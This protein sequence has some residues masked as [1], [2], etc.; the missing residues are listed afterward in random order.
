MSTRD[1]AD[2][3]DTLETEKGAD[4]RGNLW[5]LD[6]PD[7]RDGLDTIDIVD[8]L[9]TLQTL[10]GLLA[11]QTVETLKHCKHPRLTGYPGDCRKSVHS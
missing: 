8:N 2:T 6:I 7:R 4:T 1:A 10:Q 9:R 11:A 3:R 5:P